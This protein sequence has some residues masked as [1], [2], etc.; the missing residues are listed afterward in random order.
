[1]LATAAALEGRVERAGH[2][3]GAVDS[4]LREGDV[5][6]DAATTRRYVTVLSSLSGPEFE[7]AIDAGRTLTLADAVAEAVSSLHPGPI[8]R[9][10]SGPARGLKGARGIQT[11]LRPSKRPRRRYMTHIRAT[12]HAWSGM[13]GAAADAVAATAS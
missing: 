9:A 4:Y 11:R 6:L 13:F 5:H 2:L 10:G 3:W 8:T 1:G 7:A 12:T